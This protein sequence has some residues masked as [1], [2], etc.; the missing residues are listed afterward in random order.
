MGLIALPLLYLLITV[1]VGINGVYRSRSFHYFLWICLI[2]AFVLMLVSL[3]MS[4]MII[5]YEK[6]NI[7]AYISIVEVIAQLLMV[8]ALSWIQ[9][10]RLAIYGVL[11]ASIS[12]WLRGINLI[13]RF[14][15]AFSSRA[16]SREA[17]N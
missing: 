10:D 6:M 13:S 12:F 9:A 5:S 2:T 11:M 14:F 8:Y 15:N 4:S 1:L 16:N 17:Q 7:F 3:I